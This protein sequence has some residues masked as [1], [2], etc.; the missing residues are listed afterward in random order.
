MGIN[1][2][3]GDAGKDLGVGFRLGV[4]LGGHINEMLSA[5]AELTLDVVNLDNATGDTNAADAVFAFSPL[6]HIP[7]G[8]IEFA[9]GP[10]LGFRSYNVS[11]KAG[12]AE[13][14]FKANGYVFGVNAGAF[15]AVSNSVS[16][17]GLLS[18][19]IRSIH[20]VCQTFPGQSEA[21]SKVDID[22]GDANKVIG[23]AA[24]ALF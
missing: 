6:V 2:Y 24:A 21:C 18:A 14:K 17:G 22:T 10:K 9:V 12:G 1:S 15:V 13:T 3:Q 19:E 8:N 7:M 11:V 16:L 5:N 4:L 23:L 20:E